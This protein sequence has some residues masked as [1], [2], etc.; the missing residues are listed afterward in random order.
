MEP[1]AARRVVVVDDEHP[2]QGEYLMNIR[3]LLTTAAVAAIVGAGAMAATTSAADARTVCN[4]Y[5]DCWHETTRYDYPAPLRVTFHNNRWH[6]NNHRYNWRD[7]HDGRGYYRQGLWV[8][9]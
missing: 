2:N 6:S 4:N 5:G 7:N 3:N 1:W 9:F 8:T